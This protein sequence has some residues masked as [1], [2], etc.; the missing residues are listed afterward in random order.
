MGKVTDAWPDECYKFNYGDKVRCTFNGKCG[1]ITSQRFNCFYQ[2]VWAVR[3]DDGTEA[4]ITT[5]Q[6][7]LIEP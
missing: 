5:N 6:L 3:F 7:Q 4:E 1:A 2:L